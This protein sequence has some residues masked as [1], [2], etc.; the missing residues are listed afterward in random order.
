METK[1]WKAT[2]WEHFDQ[3]DQVYG[4]KHSIEPPPENLRSTLQSSI[5]HPS[6]DVSHESV[7]HIQPR[8]TSST[9]EDEDEHV[10]GA[11]CSQPG[12]VQ[13]DP[14]RRRKTKDCET[15]DFLKEEPKEEEKRFQEVMELERQKLSTERERIQEM[16][17]LKDILRQMLGN[18]N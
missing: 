15:L 4:T 16:R 18:S 7:P 3:L 13:R 14:T 10:P 6:L 2:Y 1:N 9:V 12:P 17:D 11:P 5:L 8:D